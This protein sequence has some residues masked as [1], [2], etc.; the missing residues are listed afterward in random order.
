MLACYQI[1]HDLNHAKKS[2]DI[3]TQLQK[4]IFYNIL[5]HRI[6]GIIYYLECP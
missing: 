1:W 5:E 2:R 6:G 4:I 3:M